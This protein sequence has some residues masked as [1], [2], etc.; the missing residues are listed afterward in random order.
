MRLDVVP[1]PK[2]ED[3]DV[4]KAD[5]DQGPL[6]RQRKGRIVIG[7]L[8]QSPLQER[9]PAGVLVVVWVRHI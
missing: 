1:T 5:L 4:M 2:E 9:Q 6:R 3:A 8:G 7:I